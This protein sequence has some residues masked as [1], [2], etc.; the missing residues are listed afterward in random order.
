MPMKAKGES[1]SQRVRQRTTSCPR[2]NK[3]SWNNCKKGSSPGPR[4]HW[5]TS[6]RNARS[7]TI[8][9]SRTKTWPSS[10]RH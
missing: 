1:G 2:P 6:N 8:N 5:W 3:R 10:P 9:R 4:L 7:P